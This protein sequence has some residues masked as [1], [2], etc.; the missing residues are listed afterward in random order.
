VQGG[1]VIADWPGLATAQLHEGRDL[2]PTL[3]L[4]ALITSAVA[5]HYG[6]DFRR[7]AAALFPNGQAVRPVEGLLRV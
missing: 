5:Q 6:L 1:R 4:D 3:G 7:T 2:R